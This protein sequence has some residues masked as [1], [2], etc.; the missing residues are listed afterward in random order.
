[1]LYGIRLPLKLK[2][3]VYKSYVRPSFLYVSHVECLKESEMGTLQWTE[4][5]MVRAMC[6]VQ[7]E[8]RQRA[9][10]LMLTLGLNEIIDQLAMANSA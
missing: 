3:A 6:G 5:Y 10:D 1:M 8:Y 7:L 2:G 9:N 4:R